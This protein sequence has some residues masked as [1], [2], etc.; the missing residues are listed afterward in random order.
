[1]KKNESVKAIMSSD[2]IFTNINGKISEVRKLMRENRINH[3]PVI[4]DDKLIGLVSRTDILRSS[5]SNIFVQNDDASDAQLDS[6]TS[7]S[8]IMTTEIK[9]VT[10]TTSIRE[11]ATHL[12]TANY[13]SLPVIDDNE[14]LVG[15]VTTKDIIRYLV[16]QY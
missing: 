14:K 3:V 10:P 13:S 1:M 7:I 15:I 9:T 2:I 6:T 12:L 5:F 4:S 11:V 8:D 16:E